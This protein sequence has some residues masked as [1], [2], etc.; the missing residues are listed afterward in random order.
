MGRLEA[1]A[2][3]EL[4]SSPDPDLWG[5]VVHRVPPAPRRPGASRAF[6]S[7][8]VNHQDTLGACFSS[9]T[10]DLSDTISDR[11][12][13]PLEETAAGLATKNLFWDNSSVTYLYFF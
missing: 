12:R 10:S 4:V 9:C 8:S 7:S 1:E 5:P 6:V 2:L 3:A 11:S 13:R